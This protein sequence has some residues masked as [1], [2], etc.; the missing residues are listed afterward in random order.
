V[1]KF[2]ILNSNDVQAEEHE[3]ID[4]DLEAIKEFDQKEEELVLLDGT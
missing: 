4:R 3:A 1:N 2:F